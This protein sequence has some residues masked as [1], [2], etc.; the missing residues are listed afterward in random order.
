MILSRV[1]SAIQQQVS[2]LPIINDRFYLLT[3]F[4][5]IFVKSETVQINRYLFIQRIVIQYNAR[6][7]RY[8]IP[9][10]AKISEKRR[11]NIFH[12]K[13]SS[14]YVSKIHYSNLCQITKNHRVYAQNFLLFLDSTGSV[15]ERLLYPRVCITFIVNSC[16]D[17]ISSSYI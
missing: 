12:L 3:Q 17:Q 1:N 8:G 4:Y 7:I 6:Y 5:N 14:K 13:F 16:K 2:F 9:L 15:L 10:A 11:T